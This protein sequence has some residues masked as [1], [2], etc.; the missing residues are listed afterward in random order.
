MFM[1]RLPCLPMPPGDGQDASN[2]A[3][4]SASGEAGNG[5]F[6]VRRRSADEDR[7]GPARNQV[8]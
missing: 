5:M 1:S 7:T 3:C 4:P 6:G 8:P 2:I